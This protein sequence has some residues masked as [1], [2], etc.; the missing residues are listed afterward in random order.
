MMTSRYCRGLLTTVLTMTAL[1]LQ[2]I[3]TALANAPESRSQQAAAVKAI[4]LKQ[5]SLYRLDNSYYHPIDALKAGKKVP[6]PL[7]TLSEPLRKTLVGHG[8]DIQ[9]FATFN[10][11]E[12]GGMLAGA[13]AKKLINNDPRTVL[14]IPDGTIAHDPV[15]SRGPVVIQGEANLMGGIYGESLVLYSEKAKFSQDEYSLHIGLP[16]VLQTSPVTVI[17]PDLKTVQSNPEAAL[18][19]KHYASAAVEQFAKSQAMGCGF[20]G[21][22]WNNNEKGQYDWCLSV[23]Q[24]FADQ[25]SAFRSNALD[26]CIAEKVSPDHPQNQLALPESCRDPAKSYQAVKKISHS[27]RYLNEVVSPVQNGLI[28]YDYNRDGKPDYVFLEVNDQQ[29]RVAMCFSDATKY[30]RQLT[31]ITFSPDNTGLHSDRYNLTQQGE[32]LV[33]EV[34]YFQHNA[35]SSSRHVE[36][37]FE[38]STKRFRVIKNEVEVKPVVYDGQ[39]YPMGAPPTPVLF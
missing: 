24:P 31:D 23:L 21:P 26:R 16:S 34:R 27:F 5:Q 12:V 7:A 25:E 37:R 6:N 20:A 2:A 19:C 14:V 9:R 28:A 32:K 29:S 10:A 8:V 3:P 38:P 35:G 39:P 33:V 15:Y 11:I 22:R 1:L 30:R 18:L 36:Y 17:T 4:I 13:S